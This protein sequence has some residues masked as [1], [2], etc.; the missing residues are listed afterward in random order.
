MLLAVKYFQ[1][2][3]LSKIYSWYLIHVFCSTMFSLVQLNIHNASIDIAYQSAP[4]YYVDNSQQ[5]ILICVTFTDS[6]P[7]T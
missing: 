2:L 5:T 1:D 4:M 7:C 6:N 3:F